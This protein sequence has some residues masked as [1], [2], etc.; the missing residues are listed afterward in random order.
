MEYCKA[1]QILPY[2][3]PPHSTHLLQPLDV[4]LLGPLQ[5]YYCSAIDKAIRQG[6]HGIYKCNFLPLYLESRQQTYHKDNTQ[7]PFRSCVI[8][9]LNCRIILHKLQQ[10]AK[11]PYGTNVSEILGEPATP[12]NSGDITL[13]MRQTNLQIAK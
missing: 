4:G 6:I 1:H 5:H 9:P 2:C 12:Q 7:T 11:S 13:L 3:L 8:I 10:R